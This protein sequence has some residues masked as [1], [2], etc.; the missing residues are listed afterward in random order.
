M[1]YYIML[2][3]YTSLVNLLITLLQHLLPSL[4]NFQRLDKYYRF[5]FIIISIKLFRANDSVGINA[6][7]H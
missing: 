6:I 5:S 7:Y 3:V 4:L 1:L 2:F